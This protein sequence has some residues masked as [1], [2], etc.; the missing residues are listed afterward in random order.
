MIENGIGSN[1]FN[2]EMKYFGELAQ[3]KEENDKHNKQLNIRHGFGINEYENREYYI[4]DWKNNKR[5]GSGVYF[6]NSG[7]IFTGFFRKDKFIN[8][9]FKFVD[10][11]VYNGDIINNKPDGFGKYLNLD[12]SIYI[13]QFQ[14]GSK[15]N[16][17]LDYVILPNG[18]RKPAQ[19]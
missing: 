11:T 10:G 8:G 2:T 1:V 3:K 4:G 19:L 14:N 16:G 15:V 6:F 9:N 18:E 7:N 5:N 12:G 17:K 13:G